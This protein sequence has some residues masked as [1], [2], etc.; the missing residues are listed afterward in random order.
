[1]SD[2]Q[3]VVARTPHVPLIDATNALKAASQTGPR[4]D[5][6]VLGAGMAGLAAAYEL[7]QRGHKVTVLEGSKRVGGRVLTHRFKDGSHVELG[8][9]RV[10]LSHDYTLHYIKEVGLE[11]TLI[12][13]FNATDQNFLDIRDVICRRADG[14]QRIYPLWGIPGA[15]PNPALYPQYPGNAI[16]GW[17]LTAVIETMTEFERGIVMSGGLGTPRL[18]YLDGLSVGDFLAR[19]AS[20]E[21]G[22]LINAFTCLDEL[23]E[24]SLSIFLRDTLVGIG[25]GLKTL[26]GGMSGLP[27]GLHKKL[28]PGTVLFEHEVTAIEIDSHTSVKVRCQS[29]GGAKELQVPFVICTI[30]YSVL[31]LVSLVNFSYAKIKAIRDMSYINATKV[32][33][34]CKSRFWETKYGIYGGS[35]VSDR[36]QR[37]TYYP[38]D[39]AETVPSK[40]D[41]TAKLPQ[42]R[43]FAN[44]HAA[45]V[46]EP[47]MRL[48]P[49]ADPN[50]P[51]ALLGA[52]SW[53]AD[54][55]RLGVLSRDARADAVKRGIARFHPEIDQQV[56]EHASIDWGQHRWSGGAFAYLLPG[57]LESMYGI[58]KQ[59]EHRVFFAGEHCSAEQA[60]IQGALI[61]AFRAV[62]D[63]TKA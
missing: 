14:A 57:Q 56:T 1:M 11:H 35:S 18:R 42:S 10:P 41:D 4:K 6:L 40:D 27:E 36:V 9:M 43:R 29:P 51:G 54:A 49:K 26:R 58:A 50:E 44:I 22:E 30:P 8:A 31:R 3:H 61:S 59:P 2:D 13:F 45:P 39:H 28:H 62:L 23:K 52:Y 21:V 17:L 38:M 7:Q 5:V 37:Q 63:I 34:A 53:G 33:F 24:K 60:W 47:Q 48:N 19:G 16:L 20:S 32:G 46:A 55:N 12:D 25:G 15:N